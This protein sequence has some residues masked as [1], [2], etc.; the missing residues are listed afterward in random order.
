MSFFHRADEASPQTTFR[1]ETFAVRRNTSSTCSRFMSSCA[2]YDTSCHVHPPH[3]AK[4]GHGDSTACGDGT[5]VRTLAASAKRPPPLTPVTRATTVSPG[6]ARSHSS[7][8]PDSRRH[9][10]RPPN[11]SAVHPPPPRP[12]P[13][14]AARRRRT[15]RRRTPRRGAKRRRRRWMARASTERMALP[16]EPGR[17]EA[18]APWSARDARAQPR[19]EP[20]W[21]DAIAR[22]A[23]LA[24]RAS[25]RRMHTLN[26]WKTKALSVVSFGVFSCVFALISLWST[27]GAIPTRVAQLVRSLRRDGG[28]PGSHDGPSWRVEARALMRLV[29]PI[30]VQMGSQQLMVTTDLIFLGRLGRSPSRWARSRRRCSTYFGSASRGSAPRS[31]RWGRRRT[32]RGT[33]WPCGTG[34]RSPPGPSARAAS[35]RRRCCC[36]AGSSPRGFCLKTPPPRTRWA[37]SARCCQ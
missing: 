8:N 25:A 9:T 2:A 20:A 35:P 28:M 4:C 12:R 5:E 6:V 34:P 19:V 17:V 14:A 15:R 13:R 29:V 24:R 26:L 30:C 16:L 23:A 31:T 21:A 32:A 22:I 1:G 36:A 37:R 33:H 7:T 11:A 3:S 18:P 27:R 10:P